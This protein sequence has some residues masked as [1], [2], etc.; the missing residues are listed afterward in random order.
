MSR[1]TSECS[2]YAKRTDRKKQF[3]SPRVLREK[4]CAWDDPSETPSGAFSHGERSGWG[5]EQVEPRL[6][7]DS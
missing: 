1:W 4:A 3:P 2:M 5:P 7:M 6:R